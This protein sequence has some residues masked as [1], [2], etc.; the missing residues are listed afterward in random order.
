MIPQIQSVLSNQGSWHRS[1]I[2][3]V[4]NTSGPEFGKGHEPLLMGE[5]ITADFLLLA[6]YKFYISKHPVFL[7]PCSELGWTDIHKW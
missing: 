7:E 4:D 6:L 2:I 5:D 1:C 3:K